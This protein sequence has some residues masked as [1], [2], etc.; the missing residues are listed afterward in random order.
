MATDLLS[1]AV[2]TACGILLAKEIVTKHNM[3]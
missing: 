1:L 3:R 2:A